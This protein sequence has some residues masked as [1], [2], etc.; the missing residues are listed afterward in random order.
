M[1]N[2]NKITSDLLENL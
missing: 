2:N 1:D